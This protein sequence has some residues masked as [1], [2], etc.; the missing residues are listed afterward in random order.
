MPGARQAQEQQIA[1]PD[2][3]GDRARDLGAIRLQPRQRLR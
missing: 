3:V 1:L 2:D